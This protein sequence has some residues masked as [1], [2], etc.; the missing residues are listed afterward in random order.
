MLLPDGA[1]KY[2]SKIFNDDWMRENG[3]LDEEPGLGTVRDLLARQAGEQ[4]RHRR[5][6]ATRC[7]TSSTTLKS[8]RHQPAP[9]RSRTASSAASSPR[10][11]CC[12]TWSRAAG[13]LD[14]H[15]RRARRE[16]LRDGHARHEDRAA[17]GRAERRQDRH[18]RPSARRWSA[19]SPR[20][21]SSI[22][23]PSARSKRKTL[24]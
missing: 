20:S 22:S 6:R 5:R 10:S 9:G 14:S 1:Q 3:F 19:S 18:R 24:R 11:I 13:T 2:I 8:L 12:A 23:S 21:T 15:H 16:R 7:A 4:R 17:A